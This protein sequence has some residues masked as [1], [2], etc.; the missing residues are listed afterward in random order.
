MV[1]HSRSFTTI[2]RPIDRQELIEMHK[3]NGLAGARI[4]ENDLQGITNKSGLCA[5][6]ARYGLMDQPVNIYGLS[7]KMDL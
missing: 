7:H 5:W 2:R 6:P 4:I 3:A 1:Y